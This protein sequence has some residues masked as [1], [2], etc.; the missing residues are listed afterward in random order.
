MKVTQLVLLPSIRLKG[1][2][3]GQK[4]KEASKRTIC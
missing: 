2:F 1:S 4:G 3:E